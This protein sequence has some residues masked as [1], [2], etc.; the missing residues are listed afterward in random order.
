MKTLREMVYEAPKAEIV[1]I[2]L[3]GILCVSGGE[4]NTEGFDMMNVNP[5]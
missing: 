2:D 4:G 5:F 3:Q 1:V